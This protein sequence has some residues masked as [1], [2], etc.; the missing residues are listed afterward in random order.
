MLL[1][2][3]GSVNQAQKEPSSQWKKLACIDTEDV[4]SAIRE[5]IADGVYKE[6][7]F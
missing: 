6:K 1:R 7:L 5:L 2:M 4:V 3:I